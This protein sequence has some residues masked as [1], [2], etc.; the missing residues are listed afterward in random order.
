M[1]QKRLTMGVDIVVVSVS[2]HLA[3]HNDVVAGAVISSKDV[4]KKIFDKEYTLL[5]ASMSPHDA[6][7]VRGLIQV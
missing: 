1:F 2:K 6:T 3:G 5:G 7:L 4:M